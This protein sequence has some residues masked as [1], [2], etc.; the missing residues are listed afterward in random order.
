MVIGYLASMIFGFI[1]GIEIE[2]RLHRVS[3]SVFPASMESKASLTGFKEQAKLYQDAVVL[4]EED[5]STEAKASAME[6]QDALNR[7]NDPD[8][9]FIRQS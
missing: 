3:E 6:A 2:S 4:E 9:F 1:L 5:R 8:R 7:L